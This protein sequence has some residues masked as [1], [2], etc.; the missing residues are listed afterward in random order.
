MTIEQRRAMELRVERNRR[1]GVGKQST[2]NLERSIAE[3]R[4]WRESIE[5]KAART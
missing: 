2:F 1:S 5:P 3:S 4:K